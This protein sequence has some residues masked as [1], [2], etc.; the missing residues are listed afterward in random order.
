MKLCRFGPIGQERPGLIDDNGMLRD[1]SAHI[2]DINPHILSP[3]ELARLSAIEIADLPAVSGD[4]R[5]GVPWTGISKYVG[6]GLNFLDHAREAGLQA[7]DEPIIFLK[8]TTAICGPNDDTVVP[9][10]STKLDWEVE[11]GIVIG[12][13][14]QN[15]PKSDAVRH[16]AGYCLLNDISE[17]G[18]QLQSSQWDKGKGCDS[19]GPIGP[20]LVTA[21]EVEDP[22]N[23]GMWL[24]VNGIRMQSSDTSQMIFDVPT[25][26]SYVS[27]FMTLLPGDVIATGTPAGVGMGQKPEPQWLLPG[28]VVELS[29]EGLGKQRQTVRPR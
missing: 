17:R 16:I 1:L 21:D 20:W 4:V 15:I 12:T 25:L 28:D 27:R 13:K 22:G 18:F 10:G 26:V 14:A 24:D 5:Y 9:H 3:G 8:A 11:L 19:F 7:P 6:I 23:L 2:S 29:I